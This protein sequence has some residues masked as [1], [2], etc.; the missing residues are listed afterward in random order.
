MLQTNYEG[1]FIEIFQ[2]PEEPMV[3]HHELQVLVGLKMP[4]AIG[5]ENIED[6]KK[7]PFFFRAAGEE[8]SYRVKTKDFIEALKKYIQSNVIYSF[9]GYTEGRYY[10]YFSKRYAKLVESDSKTQSG[11]EEFM[12]GKNFQTC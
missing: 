6:Q 4:L 5:Y 7:T 3:P 9:M 12:S 8:D 11:T 1:G 10:V 2:T